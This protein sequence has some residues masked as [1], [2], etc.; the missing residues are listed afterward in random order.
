MRE[1]GACQCVPQHQK[2]T[3]LALTIIVTQLQIAAES[4]RVWG[5]WER[6]PS[7]EETMKATG[8]PSWVILSEVAKL[9][10]TGGA[11]S[12]A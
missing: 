4:R 12:E 3:V 5:P 9:K 6:G 2:Y 7:E 10:I 1:R 11:R 8:F